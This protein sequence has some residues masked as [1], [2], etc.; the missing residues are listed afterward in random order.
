METSDD[1]KRDELKKRLRNLQN[2]RQNQ[3]KSKYVKQLQIEKEEKK[4]TEVD[5]THDETTDNGF[6]EID[7]TQMK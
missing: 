5:N 4:T 1:T 3:R 7:T 6:I 2:N